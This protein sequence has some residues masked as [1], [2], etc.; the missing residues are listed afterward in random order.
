[1]NAPLASADLS[2][3]QGGKGLRQISVPGERTVP[4]LDRLMQVN[5]VIKRL[6][7]PFGGAIG[8]FKPDGGTELELGD[9]DLGIGDAPK[10]LFGIYSNSTAA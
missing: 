10:A 7:K 3:L 5:A 2:A 1:M 4:R 8:M 6:Q 9:A